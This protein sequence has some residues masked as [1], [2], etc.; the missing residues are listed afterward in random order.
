MD[1]PV[2]KN[3]HVSFLTKH[4]DTSSI[5]FPTPASN[6]FCSSILIS[7]FKQVAPVVCLIGD[8]ELFSG[9]QLCSLVS[10]LNVWQTGSQTI[11]NLT[12]SCWYYHFLS[13]PSQA[14][15]PLKKVLLFRL[16]LGQWYLSVRL[17]LMGS[18]FCDGFCILIILGSIG[19]FH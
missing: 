10:A 17:V 7:H 5:R 16:I 6:W 14:I 2:K 1:Y 3:Q 18:V 11:P 4:P 15:I 12:S 13:Y 19:L 8:T 9:F